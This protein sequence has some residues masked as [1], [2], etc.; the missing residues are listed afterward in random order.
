MELRHLR[1]FVTVAEEL[2]FGRAAKRLN[3]TQPPLSRQIQLLERELGV[4][5]FERTSHSVALSAAGRAFL[6][7]ARAVLAAS[8]N[9]A[10]VAR[11]AA[12]ARSGGA[13]AVGFIGA[14]TYAFLP[15]MVSLARSELPDV[16][17]TLK[18]MTGAA[19]VE[20]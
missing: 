5:L 15:R 4:R 19:Q 17:L 6:P 1:Y 12:Q 16:T 14:S 20:A 7:E 11:R 9:A 3:M 8:E 10:R 18:E 2:H 13:L